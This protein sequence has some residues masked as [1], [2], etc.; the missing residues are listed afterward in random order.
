MRDNVP[1]KYLPLALC[2][3]R[4]G[5]LS[6]ATAGLLKPPLVEPPQ[7]GRRRQHL[8]PA[9]ITPANRQTPDRVVAAATGSFSRKGAT[10][11]FGSEIP[12]KKTKGIAARHRVARMQNSWF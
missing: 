1:V 5:T 10:P 2:S 4:A 12:A 6:Q 11:N 3:G 7:K 8:T 9:R